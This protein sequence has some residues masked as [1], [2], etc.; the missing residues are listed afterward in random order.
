M[1]ARDGK[2]ITKPAMCM[3]RDMMTHRTGGLLFVCLL[4]VGT[5]SGCISSRSHDDAKRLVLLVCCVEAH[6]AKSD[7][8][9][10]WV[11]DQ[12]EV[13]GNR[14]KSVGTSYANR[15]VSVSHRSLR[16]DERLIGGYS[17]ERIGVL[18]S[19]MEKKWNELV[20]DIAGSKGNNLAFAGVLQ[21]ESGYALAVLVDGAVI[22][23]LVEFQEADSTIHHA[24][25][26]LESDVLDSDGVY[27]IIRR[28]IAGA[29]RQLLLPRILVSKD[30]AKVMAK[31][32]KS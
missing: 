10:F 23:G 25:E 6:D 17:G 15:T 20:R 32:L 19:V 8:A 30:E 16:A 22:L 28:T 24:S 27:W 11:F 18:Q 12:Q 31:W 4:I 2:C 14:G 21:G 13:S 5:C 9:S 29:S 7:A 26:S 1:V 3:L